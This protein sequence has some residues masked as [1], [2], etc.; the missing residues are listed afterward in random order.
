MDPAPENFDALR[1]L[2]A[3]KG[4][5][6]PP[7]GFFDRFT[8]QV[9]ARLSGPQRPSPATLWQ[10]IAE[11]LDARPMLAGAYGLAVGGLML[12]AVNLLVKPDSTP[13]FT[14]QPPPAMEPVPALTPEPP[15]FTPGSQATML[16]SSN[17]M[18]P[19]FLANPGTGTGVF[20]LPASATNRQ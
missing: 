14:Q 11:S 3:L 9:R 16:A 13:G 4:R 19:S 18:P 17:A 2:L 6:Q 10:R 12:L 20:T 15:T 5:E 8:S 1:K 7:P